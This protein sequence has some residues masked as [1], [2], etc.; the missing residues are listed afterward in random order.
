MRAGTSGG[1][2]R[3]LPEIRISAPSGSILLQ[4]L[5]A[6]KNVTETRKNE[7]WPL[8]QDDEEWRYEAVSDYR[9]C[10]VCAGWEGDVRGPEIPVEFNNYARWGKNHI[11]PGTHIGHPELIDANSPDA[12]GGCRCNLYWDDYL[13]VL[14]MRLDTEL[15]E[16]VIE[17]FEGLGWEKV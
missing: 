16:S 13:Y 14:L 10:Y 2:R 8:F 4:A 7:G 6:M 15:R 12:Y 1:G 5:E 3:R 9:T 11:K 17:Y